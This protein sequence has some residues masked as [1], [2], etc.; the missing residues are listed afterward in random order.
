[1]INFMQSNQNILDFDHKIIDNDIW[2]CLFNKII[3]KESLVELAKYIQ[4]I[5]KM[6]NID[7]KNII[8]DFL[9]YIIRH[10][11]WAITPDFLNF[12]E[13]VMHFQDCKNYI[14]YWLVRLTSILSPNL[15]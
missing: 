13:N 10:K 14:Q 4:Y 1:M 7:K 3:N 9:N 15:A 2:S 6:Y 12:V 8:N 11:D 5:S